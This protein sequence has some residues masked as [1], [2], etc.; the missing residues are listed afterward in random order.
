MRLQGLSEGEAADRKAAEGCLALF[1]V[2]HP[3]V[4]VKFLGVI[5]HLL[6]AFKAHVAFIAHVQFL[7][8]SDLLVLHKLLHLSEFS[9]AFV[10]PV[11]FK[12][13]LATA[14]P[15]VPATPAQV[16]FDFPGG[17]WMV[18]KPAEP[19]VAR[20]TEIHPSV[21]IAVFFFVA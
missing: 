7:L 9:S 2:F 16:A 8:M 20:G 13:D 3:V 12:Q 10:T 17:L 14:V 19:A 18:E 11:F 21:V 6:H 4:R 1:L 15:G 5:A